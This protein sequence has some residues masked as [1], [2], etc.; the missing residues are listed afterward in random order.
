VRKW[1]ESNATLAGTEKKGYNKPT[2]EQTI[3]AYIPGEE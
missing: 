3:R 1:E 2:W